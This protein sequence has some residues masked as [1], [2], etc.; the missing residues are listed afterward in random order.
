ML[1]AW[2]NYCPDQVTFSRAEPSHPTTLYKTVAF[3]KRQYILA[4]KDADCGFKVQ[5]WKSLKDI[6]SVVDFDPHTCSPATHYKMK[7][8]SSV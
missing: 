5:V 3:N 8:T 2:E 6:V 7:Q 4:C 1:S